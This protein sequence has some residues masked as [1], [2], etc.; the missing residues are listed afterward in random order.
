AVYRVHRNGQDMYRATLQHRDTERVV[1][2]N[3][4]GTPVNIEDVRPSEMASYRQDPNAWYRNYDD[5]VMARQRYYVQE[6]QRVTATVEHP[7]RI[8]L[9]RVPP[10]ARAT[11]I[12]EAGGDT[13]K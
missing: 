3:S 5:R 13:G 8:D 7:E 1:L 12:A 4:A 11:L 2:L 6:A 10:A 9:D